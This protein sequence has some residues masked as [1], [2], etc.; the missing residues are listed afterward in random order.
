[1][2]SEI[3]QSILK[4]MLIDA[5]EY[6]R[7]FGSWNPGQDPNDEKDWLLPNE[8]EVHIR[9]IQSKLNLKV[10]NEEPT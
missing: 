2:F 1:M 6:C 7:E 10:L 4:Q 8:L 9:S 5:L 3:E